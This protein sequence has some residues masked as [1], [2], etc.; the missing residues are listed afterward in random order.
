MRKRP[1]AWNQTIAGRSR[2]GSGGIFAFF[3]VQPPKCIKNWLASLPFP[4]S[5]LSPAKE[6]TLAAGVLL[7]LIIKY[8]NNI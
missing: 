3:I 6:M 2:C 4:P 5:T 8:Q 1:V 7:L